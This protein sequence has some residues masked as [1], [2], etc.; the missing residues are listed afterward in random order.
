MLDTMPVLRGA[1]ATLVPMDP[2][3]HAAG[4]F[5]ATAPDTFRFF[6]S[7]PK[8]WD[9]GE[10]RDYL[11]A[12]A[13]SP[14]TRAFVAMSAS[15]QIV[16]SSSYMDID[17]PNRCVEIGSTW[18]SPS[19]RGTAINPQCKLLMLAHAFEV[20]GCVRVTLK[21][22]ARNEHSQRA[23]SKLGAVREGTLRRHRI[24]SDGFV[25]DTVYFSV[26]QEEWG[27]TRARLCA[28]LGLDPVH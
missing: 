15:G 16:G 25:R 27:S 14:K 10:F 21:C 22:D 12:H 8:S 24:L 1:H 4:L 5:A 13:A 26:V 6:L 28:R 17:P 7:G 20:L 19:V 23:I 9:L 18:Y 3:E 11:S 2:A